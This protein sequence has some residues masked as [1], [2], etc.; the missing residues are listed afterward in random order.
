MSNLLKSDRLIP[1]YK[2][3][4]N[5]EKYQWAKAHMERHM[6]MFWKF[7]AVDLGKDV[8]HYKQASPEE[9]AFITNVMKLFTGNEVIVG[10]GYDVLTR[11]FKP[12]EVL[13]MLRQFN[14]RENTHIMAYSLFTETLGMKDSIYTEFLDVPV[15]STKTE[16]LEKAKV[17]KYEDYKAMGMSDAELDRE[18]RRA[19]ARMIGVY[20]GGTETVSL[21]AQ[22]AMLLA[23]QFQ[24]KYPGLC[25]IVEYSIKDE[26]HHSE[27][28]CEL[29]RRYI[30]ENMD[31]WDDE[32][33]FDIYEG[34][35]EIVAYEEALIDY[36]NPPH[37]S[38]AECKVYVRYQADNALKQMGMK[39][40]YHS[41]NPFPWMD[42]VTGMVLTD[43]FS[44]RVTAYSREIVGTR[45][46]LRNKLQLKKEEH[47]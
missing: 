13:M 4:V 40:N 15:M 10:T 5:A 32:L 14:A 34:I 19:V 12:T 43:F 20:A 21:Y 24:G 3:P 17:H 30:A 37:I 36:L 11:I 27:A 26:A 8:E 33:K 47:Q 29:F 1:V 41:V 45:E 2:E 38:N 46:E 25:T 18:F 7:D 16:Y 31:I 6:N 9:Q 35:R 42:E 44:G 39:P 28:N 22:F 23:Y